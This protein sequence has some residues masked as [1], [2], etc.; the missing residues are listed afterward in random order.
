MIV[1]EGYRSE[2]KEEEV[3]LMQKALILNAGM[4]MFFLA[5]CIERSVKWKS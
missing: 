1:D 3:V 4:R 5:R 2:G